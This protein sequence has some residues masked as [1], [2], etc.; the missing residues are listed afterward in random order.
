MFNLRLRSKTKIARHDGSVSSALGKQKAL[1]CTANLHYSVRSCLK[2]QG[3]H[4]AS[5]GAQ[6]TLGKTLC[7]ILQHKK[8][9][10][11]T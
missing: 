7:L 8:P 1:E 9:R 6:S 3:R 10:I 2:T 5:G 11:R 4:E